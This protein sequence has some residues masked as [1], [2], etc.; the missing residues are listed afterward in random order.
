M[1]KPKKGLPL[2]KIVIAIVL[3]ACI[4][5]V[6]ARWVARFSLDRWTTASA[7]RARESVVRAQELYTQGNLAQAREVL[8]PFAETTRSDSSTTEALLL[9]AQIEERQGNSAEANKCLEQAYQRSRETPDWVRA[10]IAYAQALERVADIEK[11]KHV[12]QEVCDAAPPELRA[13]ALTLLGRA[14][15]RGNDLLAAR[16]L[17]REAVQNAA[18]DSPE[19]REAV[20]ALGRANVT[21]IFS[22]TQTPESKRYAVQKGDSITSIGNQ[23]NTTQGLLLRANNLEGDSPRLNLGQQLK[24]T[25]KDFRI[26]IERSKCR[27]FLADKEGIFKVYPVGLGMPGHETTLGAYKIGNK[28]K[29]PTWHKPGEGPIPPLDPR[30]ELGTRWM[31]LVPEQEGLPRDLGI[32][33][34]IAPET[35]GKFSS[36]G[37]ARLY[38]ED[39]EELYDLVVRSTPVD[40]VEEVSPDSLKPANANEAV[41]SVGDTNV[42]G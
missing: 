17:Y 4:V 20:D 40:I 3:V 7:E 15:E 2:G 36:H 29:N 39:V 28:E 8:L 31:P 27:L 5:L 16:A 30:N 41:S 23:L 38:R 24:Y 21:A 25:P 18:W 1:F 42:Q 6:G 33:G 9:L 12:C 32:H 13:P 19:W 26:I 34:T 22:P 11:A 37:C 10:A 35:V 14:A